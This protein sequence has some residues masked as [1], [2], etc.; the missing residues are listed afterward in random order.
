MNLYATIS[1][2]TPD[3]STPTSRARRVDDVRVS[4]PALSELM[5]AATDFPAEL[6]AKQHNIVVR[7]GLT[8]LFNKNHVVVLDSMSPNR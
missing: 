1:H 7:G 8:L 2:V 5:Q 3:Q 4:A 6:I